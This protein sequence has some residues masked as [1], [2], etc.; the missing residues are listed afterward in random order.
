MLCKLIFYIHVK[1][2]VFI[3]YTFIFISTNFETNFQS[4]T[5][6]NT[7]ILVNTSKAKFT[8]AS[9]LWTSS[10]ILLFLVLNIAKQYGEIE[11]TCQ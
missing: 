3:F 2:S 7:S 9:I 8:D 4:I 5:T 10:P 6:D 1:P 11:N